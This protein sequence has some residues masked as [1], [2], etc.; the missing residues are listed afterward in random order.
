MDGDSAAQKHSVNAVE[1]KL[2]CD[3]KVSK[4]NVSHSRAV[5]DVTDFQLVLACRT[6][7][8]QQILRAKSKIPTA[9]E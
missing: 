2:F 1:V 8:T 5:Q 7:V 6:H 9:K 4:N 3:K